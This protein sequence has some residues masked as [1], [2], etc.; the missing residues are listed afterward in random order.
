MAES[1]ST[2]RAGGFRRRVLDQVCGIRSRFSLRKDYTGE[3]EKRHREL[4]QKGYAK[5]S[6][7]FYHITHANL[8]FDNI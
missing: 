3:T 4:L 2:T 5:A 6:L 1:Q 7:T 8:I